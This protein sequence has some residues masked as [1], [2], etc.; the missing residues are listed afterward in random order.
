MHNIGI[1]GAGSFGIA[2]AHLL[3]DNGHQVSIWTR[4]PERVRLLS[5]AHGD[6]DKLP[7]VI[8]QPEVRFTCDMGEAIED[9]DAVVL[10]IPSVYVRETA[11]LMKP[12]FPEGALLVDCAKGL[13]E[14]TLSP[15]SDVIREE[16]AEKD[17]RIVVLSGPSHAEEVGRGVPTAIVAASNDQNAARSVQELFM[18]PTFRVYTGSDM[19][20]VE[21][22]GALKNVI[23]LAAG[24]ADGLGY[25]DNTKAAMITRGIAEIT[26]LGVALGAE[27]ETFSGLTGIGDLIVTCASMHSRNRRAGIFIGQGMSKE[28]AC[29]EVKM[30]VEGVNSA[31][32]A[33]LLA[34]KYHVEMPIITEVYRVLFENKRPADAVA[35]L[36]LRDKKAE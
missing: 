25:G 5:E 13:E 32:G 1:V 7:G 19:R 18:N 31:K 21:L 28:E 16:L 11:R 24:V 22:G 30:V 26:R 36:M 14:S 23:A 3:T 29:N 35:D 33:Y 27:A 12:H 20:G 9:A 15:L 34:Q 4:S 8:L 10:V 17:P 2:L 6:P